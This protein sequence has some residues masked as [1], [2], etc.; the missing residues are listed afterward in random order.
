MAKLG[1]TAFNCQKNY[2]ASDIIPAEDLEGHL[3]SEN[4]LHNYDIF[5]I[6]SLWKMVNPIF[7]SIYIFTYNCFVGTATY[8][9]LSLYLQPSLSNWLRIIVEWKSSIGKRLTSLLNALLH[10]VELEYDRHLLRPK[11]S[12]RPLSSILRGQTRT[13]PLAAMTSPEMEGY[14]SHKDVQHPRCFVCAAVMN[15]KTL[16]SGTSP[17]SVSWATKVHG[18]L[19]AI[20]RGLILLRTVKSGH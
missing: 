16:I 12:P 8:Q 11:P 17:A 7:P 9:T 20:I 4:N 13:V 14:Y 5:S 6:W 15:A 2:L 19:P 10:P 1:E 18:Y 3:Q